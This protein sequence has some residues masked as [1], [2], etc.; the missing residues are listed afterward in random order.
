MDLI[1][2]IEKNLGKKAKINFL[3]M[4]PGDVKITF[5]DISHSKD[6]LGYSPKVKIDQGLKEFIDWYT[7]FI[8]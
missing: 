1:Y 5:A 7:Y 8:A 4:Q 2:L 6:R 3:P